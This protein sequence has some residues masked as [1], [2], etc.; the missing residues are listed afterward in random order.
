MEQLPCE[1]FF[2]ILGKSSSLRQMISLGQ[3]NKYFYDMVQ[4]YSFFRGCKKIRTCNIDTLLESFNSLENIKLFV[5]IF[6]YKIDKIQLIHSVVKHKLCNVELVQWIIYVF[7]LNISLFETQIFNIA[8]K[9]G[10]LEIV[11][12][13]VNN[14]PE[15]CDNVKLRACSF[16]NALKS[17]NIDMVEFFINKYPDIVLGTYCSFSYPPKTPFAIACEYYNRN[18]FE[19]LTNQPINVAA[20]LLDIEVAQNIFSFSEKNIHICKYLVENYAEQII[21]LVNEKNLINRL[22]DMLYNKIVEYLIAKLGK[23]LIIAPDKLDM[24]KACIFGR[25][26]TVKYIIERSNMEAFFSMF[27]T[28]EYYFINI[29]TNEHLRLAKYFLETFPDINIHW[30]NECAFRRACRENN[31]KTAKWLIKKYPTIYVHAKQESAFRKACKKNNFAIA[32]W[33][34]QNYPTI[35]IHARDDYAFRKLCK[36]CN[37]QMLKWF[38]QKYPDIDQ[39][40]LINVFQ[41]S[42]I[43][44]KLCVAKLLEEKYQIFCHINLSS[45]FRKVVRKQSGTIVWLVRQ[46]PKIINSETNTNVN[47]DI[48]FQ[49]ACKCD[50]L[51]PQLLLQIVPSINIRADNDCAFRNVCDKKN[52]NIATW[53][54]TLCTKY[55][56]DKVTNHR[57]YFKILDQ[58][59]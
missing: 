8:C 46:L 43:N 31:F 36:T 12:W 22:H 35:N 14:F 41:K 28:K 24:A 40:I 10:N 15:I 17:G 54:C 11:K 13:A 3:C 45:L 32:K 23:N 55:R 2:E 4:N 57:I 7:P 59:S 34:L 20:D 9:A 21:R 56:I 27:G 38:I 58:Y 47:L 52:E 49:Y 51:V 53:L 16:E 33:L 1:L 30:N 44:S 6:K 39:K 19:W 50:I 48:L 26:A 5:D 25:L 37:L 42:C 18:F 29:C